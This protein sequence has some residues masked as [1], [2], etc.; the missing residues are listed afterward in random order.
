MKQIAIDLFPPGGFT[1]AGK[2]GKG[3]LAPLGTGNG[4]DI[5]AKF[6]SST[7]GLLT[8]IAIIWFIFNFFMGAIGIISAGSN[9]EALEN[10]RK[11]IV[12]SIIGLVVVVA[13]IFIIKLIG[14]LIGI[15]DILNL[16]SL[17]TKIIQ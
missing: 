2:E 4:I 15:P 10:S 14:F 7:I 8:I 11:K 12:N 6:I 5:F 1:G 16:Q 13:A 3:L 17:F 9:K